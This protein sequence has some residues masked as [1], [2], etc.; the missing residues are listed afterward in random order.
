MGIGMRVGMRRGRGGTAA[1][2]RAGN[3]EMDCVGDFKGFGTED[4]FEIFAV[5]RA[6]GVGCCCDRE[7]IFL[8][9]LSALLSFIFSR[10]FF[11]LFPATLA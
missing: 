5:R 2:R 3:G 10:F 7:G 4:F 8:L 9:F 1:G 11:F 6:R